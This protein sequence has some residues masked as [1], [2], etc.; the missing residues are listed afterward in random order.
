MQHCG[1]A[2]IYLCI[3]VTVIAL[4]SAHTLH[5][6]ASIHLQAF[7]ILIVAIHVP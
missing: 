6:I 5:T 1:C 3:Y 4:D 7:I 2:C